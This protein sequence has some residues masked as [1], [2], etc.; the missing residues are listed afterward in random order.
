MKKR[1]SPRETIEN[2]KRP[3]LET[4]YM[5]Y[6]R[7]GLVDITKKGFLHT[8]EENLLKSRF[9]MWMKGKKPYTHLHTHQSTS[10]GGYWGAVPSPADIL[11]FFGVEKGIEKTNVIAQQSIE[12]GELLGYTILKKTKDTEKFSHEEVIDAQKMLK[13]SSNIQKIQE[14]R[15]KSYNLFTDLKNY[16]ESLR[17]VPERADSILALAEKYQFNIKFLPVKG[18]KFDEKKGS[19]VPIPKEETSHS[20]ENKV[21]SILGISFLAIILFYSF[22]LT[23]NVVANFSSTQKVIGTILFILL[24]IGSYF[25][26][27][28]KK[29]KK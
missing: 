21:I 14:N 5:K 29:S 26:L 24:V 6:P 28:N 12:T 18:Y 25:Y 2:K 17:K 27:K 3:Y 20:L 15:G 10:E 22:N 7:E 11:R 8:C 23:G 16:G 9:H 1:E 13:D 19:F 4:I